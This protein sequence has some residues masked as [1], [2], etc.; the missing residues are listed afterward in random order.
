MFD[1]K[2]TVLLP[3]HLRLLQLPNQTKKPL[4]RGPETQ[5]KLNRADEY[6][7]WKRPSENAGGEFTPFSCH[8]FGPEQPTEGFTVYSGGS[9]S[10]RS[11][12][13]G[14]SSFAWNLVC[15]QRDAGR[16]RKGGRAA[17]R[18]SAG[19]FRTELMVTGSR[20]VLSVLKWDAQIGQ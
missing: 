19:S 5:L 13:W 15:P 20:V 18:S 6:T 2:A 12:G 8:F 1:P 9:F 17:I 11:L 14:S 10:W 4:T 16:S 3:R 7:E